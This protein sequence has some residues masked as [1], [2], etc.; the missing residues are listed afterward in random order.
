[1]I[2]TMHYFCQLNFPEKDSFTANL[3]HRSM[4]RKHRGVVLPFLPK[5]I[6]G[7]LGNFMFNSVSTILPSESRRLHFFY[8]MRFLYD[9]AMRSAAIAVKI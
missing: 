5:T 7:L 1:M 8:T 4:Q 2:N 6:H 9:D 3:I